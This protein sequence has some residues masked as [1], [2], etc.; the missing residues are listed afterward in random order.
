MSLFNRVTERTPD[1]INEASEVAKDLIIA[2]NPDIISSANNVIFNLS[3]ISLMVLGIVTLLAG[4]IIWQTIKL[5]KTNF[6]SHF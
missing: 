6:F 1:V 4:I 2:P 5:Y 3:F